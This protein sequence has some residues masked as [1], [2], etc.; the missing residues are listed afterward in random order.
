MI[1]LYTMYC[2]IQIECHNAIN[3][4]WDVISLAIAPRD[5]R[6]TLARCN[7]DASC[8]RHMGVA[9]TSCEDCGHF[10]AVIVCTN[11]AATFCRY[12][13]C[14]TSRGCRV[15][16]AWISREDCGHFLATIVCT[17]FAVTF[18]CHSSYKLCGNFLPS[19]FIQT[20]RQFLLSFFVRTVWQLFAVILRTNCATTFCCH[21]SYE[22]CGNFLSVLFVRTL[23]QLLSSFFIRTLRQLF[24]VTLCTNFTAT[25]CCH[26]LYKVYGNFLVPNNSDIDLLQKQNK[27]LDDML[28][29][30]GK[31]NQ[32]GFYYCNL[33]LYT[34]QGDYVCTDIWVLS[35]HVEQSSKE[36]AH[37]ILHSDIFYFHIIIF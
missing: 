12:S 19:F 16:I 11:F 37:V 17:N 23:W 26:S 1:Y 4:T 35:T 15:S 6:V 2:D 21:S 22:L 13:S 33:S 10:L 9:R 31:N 24:V 3:N 27:E 20:V 28:F 25:F 7:R 36:L 29:A 8:G 14:N 30:N 32:P 18:C 34:K 5:A